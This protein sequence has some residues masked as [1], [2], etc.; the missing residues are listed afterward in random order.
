MLLIDFGNYLKGSAQWRT[1]DFEKGG[2]GGGAE[3][4]ENMRGT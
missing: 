2:G 1:Q 4:S 3:T